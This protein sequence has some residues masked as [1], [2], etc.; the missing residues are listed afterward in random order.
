MANLSGIDK[1][2]RQAGN[3]LKKGGLD[4]LAGRG[5]TSLPFMVGA[6]YGGYTA[7]QRGEDV[8]GI[9]MSAGMY[10]A[11]GYMGHSLYKSGHLGQLGNA[12]ERKGNYMDPRRADIMRRRQVRADARRL[13]AT[14]GGAP[15]SSATQNALNMRR[16]SPIAAPAPSPAAA[17]VVPVA[18]TTPKLTYTDPTL[19]EIPD[20]RATAEQKVAMAALRRQRRERPLVQA[21]W[22]GVPSGKIPR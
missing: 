4:L 11:A 22:L 12:I 10:G 18:T 13:A 7:H 3:I 14:P 16:G 17:P 19:T 20:F 15:T 1:W 6:A 5:F 2:G 21:S 9:A 8:G